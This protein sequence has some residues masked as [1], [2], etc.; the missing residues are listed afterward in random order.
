M[1]E[2]WIGVTGIWRLTMLWHNEI[3]LK[4]L[5][6]LDKVLLTVKKNNVSFII[7]IRV[8][9][10]IVILFYIYCLTKYAIIF[11]FQTYQS[12]FWINI[13]SINITL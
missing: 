6:E 13:M 11:T 5:L 4:I 3:I 2:K 1:A 10:N 8:T 7:F 9:K 12:T